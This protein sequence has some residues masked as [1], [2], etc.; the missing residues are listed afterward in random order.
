MTQQFSKTVSSAR[1]FTHRDAT[2]TADVVQ[3]LIALAA[4]K[5]ITLY[6][7]Q[8]EVEKHKPVAGDLIKFLEPGNESES[9]F[10]GEIKSDA[11]IFIVLGGDGTILHALRASASNPLPVFAINLG[12]IGFL[13]TVDPPHE[14]EGLEAAL[15]G[16]FECHPLPALEARLPGGR[17]LLAINDVSV[18]RKSGARV[19]ELQYGI[20]GD[21]VGKVRSDGLVVSSPPGS[22]G[23][24]LANGGPVMAWGVEGY[25]VSFIAP[26]TLSARALVV[27][28]ADQIEIHNGSTDP[29]EISV[30]GRPVGDLQRGSELKVTYKRNA[31]LLAQL[32]GSS[33]YRRLQEKFGKLA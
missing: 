11:D 21:E 12:E 28:P 9:E 29:V 23:Y 17:S 7:D 16:Q 31:V 19:A 20:N 18:N 3:I 30:D 5:G 1:V 13:A 15:T 4:S 25:A 2:R 8:S 27:S 24:N 26:H 14:R 6:F 32:P 33:F 10:T 22:T